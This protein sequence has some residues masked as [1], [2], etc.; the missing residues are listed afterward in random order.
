M[1]YRVVQLENR[2]DV[3]DP[4]NRTVAQYKSEDPGGRFARAIAEALARG[5]NYERERRTSR[6]GFAEVQRQDGAPGLQHVTLCGIYQD[7]DGQLYEP[8]SVERDGL[9]ECT[10]M[11]VVEIPDVVRAF[12]WAEFTSRMRQIKPMPD[13]LPADAPV[14]RGAS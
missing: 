14:P 6:H 2:S 12:T 11:Q 4:Y 5:A 9:V 10:G 13:V 7:G 3:L 1:R 8:F